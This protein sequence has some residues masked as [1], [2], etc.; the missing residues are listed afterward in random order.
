[1]TLPPSPERYNEQI[2]ATMRRLGTAVPAPGMEDRILFR[3]AHADPRVSARRFFSFPQLAVGVAV[4][5]LGGAVIVVGSVSHSRRM[6]PIAPGIHLPAASQ[7]GVGAASAAHVATHPVIAL[8]QA[9]PRSVRKAGN[10]R[11][12]ISSGAK[13]HNGLAVPHATPGAH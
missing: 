8:P 11:A 4:T 2:D 9:R 7:E 1:M 13:K 6:L 3:L 12:V 5:V 10:G